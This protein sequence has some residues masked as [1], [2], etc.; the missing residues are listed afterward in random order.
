[1]TQRRENLGSR[2]V[3]RRVISLGGTM[4]LYVDRHDLHR[5]EIVE[6]AS[7][8]ALQ[9][10]EVRLAVDSFALTA[11]NITYAALGDLLQYWT[12]FPAPDGWG[13]VPVWGYADVRESTVDAVPVGTRVY[14][15]LPMSDD[16]VVTPGRIDDEGFTDASPH[17]A[18]MAGA[19]NRYQRVVAGD[20]RDPAAEDRQML[21]YPLFFTSFLIDDLLADLAFGGAGSV[22]LS[23]ASSKTAI[24]TAF[25]LRSRDVDVV[26]L[27]SPGNVA[28]VEGLGVYDLVVAYPE[29]GHLPG[30]T[31]A[32]IDIA[33]NA[34]VKDA[35]HRHFGADLTVSL[36]VGDTHWDHTAAAPSDA[37]GPEPIFFFAPSQITKRNEDWGRDG[38]QTRVDEAWA[39][40]TAWADGWLQIEHRHGIEAARETFL[41]LVENRA[42]PRFG[43]VVSMRD[44]PP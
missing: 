25:Q 35:V 17:R 40:Y 42:D 5:T 10:G 11:N 20:E 27:T 15:Y 26:G 7:P 4:D 38:L 39:A 21:L 18:S 37:P 6:A 19:Y 32:F 41:E 22:I 12:F 23:S 14:G 43:F 33:G 29:L 36:I 24:G 30:G 34:D 1:M 8:L 16:L 28:F 44:A 13:R 31:A 3:V 9:P 2:R